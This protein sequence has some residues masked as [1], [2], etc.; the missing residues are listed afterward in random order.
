MSLRAVSNLR[1]SR[2]MLFFQSLGFSEY[3]ADSVWPVPRVK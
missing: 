1:A 2:S 3:V